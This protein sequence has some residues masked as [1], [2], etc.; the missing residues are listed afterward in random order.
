MEFLSPSE[1]AMLL[2]A[3]GS[4]GC[5]AV[6]TYTVQRQGPDQAARAMSSAESASVVACYDTALSAS[7]PAASER[8][9]MHVLA[10]AVRAAAALGMGMVWRSEQRG[11]PPNASLTQAPIVHM[12]SRRTI[13]DSALVQVVIPAGSAPS[14]GAIRFGA[15]TGAEWLPS[16]SRAVFGPSILGTS[17]GIGL[18]PGYV[19]SI[20]PNA[21]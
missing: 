5:R 15:V 3:G 14:L 6:P 18:A 8:D 17:I 21:S 4:M 13:P 2:D 9:E 16:D 1:A 12:Q 7:D 11:A 19:H 10:S 20:H